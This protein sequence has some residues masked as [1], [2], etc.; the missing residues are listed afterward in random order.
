[1]QSTKQ[2]RRR[3]ADEEIRRELEALAAETKAQ[4]ELEYQEELQR[5]PVRAKEHMEMVDA[6][7]ALE[8]KER[9]E[10]A[11]LVISLRP[12]SYLLIPY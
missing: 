6:I 3:E 5:A 10:S 4:E 2:K 8:E 7:Q 9:E 1:M 12:S 11:K